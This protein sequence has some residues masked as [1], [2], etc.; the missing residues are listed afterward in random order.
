MGG[1][2]TVE[3]AP[4]VGSTFTLW[5][6]AARHDAGRP[7]ET[8]AER[9][10][11]AERDLT[12]L[13]TPGLGEVGELLHR[14]VDE[15]VGAYADRLRAD[16]A[17]P[18]GSAMTRIQ[19]EDHAIS[20]LADLA[21]S[22]VIVGDAGPEAV[23]LLKDGSAIQRAIAE[24]HGARRHAQGWG[25]AALRRDQQLFRE[26]VQRAVRARL[27][28]G[29]SDVDEAV[30]VLLGLIDRGEEI[31]VRAWRRASAPPR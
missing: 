8:A 17:V 13:D 22:L 6:P 24:A 1:D 27:K 19:L 23:E 29:S 4:G 26:E 2:L 14:A 30:R 3:S 25:E 28:P 31:A 20:F 15:V 11:R 10:A 16:P 9:N 5:L 12:R 7:A 18:L 21:Q